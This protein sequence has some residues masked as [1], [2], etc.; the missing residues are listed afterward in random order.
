MLRTISAH[1]A[2]VTGNLPPS[3]VRY[4]ISPPVPF[5]H[6]LPL[7]PKPAKDGRAFDPSASKNIGGDSMRSWT[8]KLVVAMASLVAIAS[9]RAAPSDAP[10]A[11]PQQFA[12]PIGGAKFEQ[13]VAHP[14]FPLV[15]F[16]DASHLGDEFI[17]AQLPEC[18]D[19]GLLILPEF[20][21]EPADG[22][23]IAYHRYTDEE[24]A[25]LPALLADPSWKA[26]AGHSRHQRAYWL[27]T[28]LGRPAGDRIQL[29]IRAQ[30][31]TSA[32]PALHRQALEQLVRDLPGLITEAKLKPAEAVATRFLH[33]NAL[34]ELGRFEE[35]RAG[36]DE[37]KAGGAKL[38]GP[39]DPDA[40]FDPGDYGELM[41]GV[42]DAGDDDRFAIDL[43][44]DNFAG[45]ACSGGD[46]AK[47][48]GRHAAAACAA[49]K[50]RQEERSALFDRAEALAADRP[51]LEK[52][53]AALPA[54]QGDKA[55]AH[56]CFGLAHERDWAAGEQLAKGDPVK[57]ATLCESTEEERRSTIETSACS[58]YEVYRQSVMAALLAGLDEPTYSALCLGEKRVAAVQYDCDN[59]F[60]ARANA[61]ARALLKDR[62]SLRPKC[63]GKNPNRP[64]PVEMACEA[65]EAKDPP[66]W[67]SEEPPALGTDPISRSALPFVE[68]ALRKAISDAGR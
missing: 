62:A 14:H 49:R 9:A 20:G 17:D 29:L 5:R 53:C 64:Y 16:P 43:L 51:A 13:Q 38:L 28:K 19:N 7:P 35:A 15:Q 65:L 46:F 6:G 31:A 48:R 21:T 36:L 2:N 55:L 22:S 63:A 12:C 50:K 59:A 30:W 4:R 45:R 10:A 34:R 8:A 32:D 24:L 68:T 26:I 18:P 57:L 11:G 52:R 37:V 39:D 23:A 1:P 25:R 67:M 60:G 56:A 58:T 47:Y 61:A 3:L 27:A 44:P 40:M 41:R 42:V 54:E 66:Y 33:I